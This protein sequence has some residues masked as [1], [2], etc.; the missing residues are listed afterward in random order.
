MVL[1]LEAEFRRR[2][3]DGR[4]SAWVNLR[5]GRQLAEADSLRTAGRAMAALELYEDVAR[6]HAGT[7]IGARAATSREALEESRP[8]RSYRKA[9][10]AELREARD[11]ISAANVVFATT[12][13][14]TARTTVGALSKR[15]RIDDLLA[16]AGGRD[17][18]K[19][20]FAR[21]RLEHLFVHLAGYE[22]RDSLAAGDT[23]RAQ[24]MLG[25]ASTIDSTR[26]R[27]AAS[28]LGLSGR[29]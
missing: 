15:L 8:V 26:A 14:S 13:T 1:W 11:A 28:S 20:V 25:V 6:R 27:A 3:R 9:E 7:P 12:R 29:Y 2:S 4:D 19:A 22:P 18:V 5:S 24:L 16:A 23:A 10:S 21:R 17:S